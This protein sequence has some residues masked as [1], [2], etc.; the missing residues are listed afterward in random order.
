MSDF[1]SDF[2]NLYVIVIVIGSIFV[3]VFF[4]YMQGKVIFMLGKIMG[5]VWDENFEEYNNLMLKW[6]SWLF[7]I[8]VVFVFVYLVFYFGFGNFKGMLN[9][10]LVGQYIVEVVKMDVIVKLL[11]DKY[12]VMDVKVVVGDKQVN[13]MGKCFFLI[14]CMQCYGV[15]VCGVKGFL[16]LIDFDWLYGG[17]LEQIKEM[18]NNGCMGVMFLYV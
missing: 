5:Y 15:D 12:M 11:F 6:W 14:Y 7:I 2:W 18:L 8:M 17:E 1:V 4:F 9:W 10:M 13:E 3:C 16:N